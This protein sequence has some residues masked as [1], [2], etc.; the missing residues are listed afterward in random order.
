MTRRAS[1]CRRSAPTPRGLVAALTAALTAGALVAA[2]TP[3][4]HATGDDD[5]RCRA[6]YVGLTYDDGPTPEHTAAL[7]SALK[8][9]HVRAT[10]FNIGQKAEKNE[11]LVAAQRDAG[12]WIANHSWSHPQMTKLSEPEMETEITRTQETIERITGTAP[13]LFRPPYGDT[14]AT[15]KGVAERLGLIQVLWDVDT[16]D[17]TGKPAEEI[18]AEA[19]TVES[20][21]IVLMHDG[22]P[23]TIEAVPLIAKNLRSRGLCAGMISPVTGRPVQP[24][25]GPPVS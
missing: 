11:A 24:D 2:T 8:E 22:Y 21:E 1:A 14:D 13:K 20:G 3:P 4:A 9:N 17:W 23:A 16:R 19:V 15:V 18:V 10:L 25:D 6:G 5:R 7:L 12:M